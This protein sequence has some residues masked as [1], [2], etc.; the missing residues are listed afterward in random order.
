MSPQFQLSLTGCCLPQNRAIRIEPD[1]SVRKHL[2][3]MANCPA[4]CG[5]L[6]SGSPLLKRCPLSLK[7]LGPFLLGLGGFDRPDECRSE[8][9]GVLSDLVWEMARQPSK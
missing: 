5:T 7:R 1:Q 9:I 8:A 4:G 2:R 6:S 3:A